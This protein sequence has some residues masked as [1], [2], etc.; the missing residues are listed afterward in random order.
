MT[1]NEIKEFLEHAKANITADL[2]DARSALLYYDHEVDEPIITTVDALRTLVD[3]YMD[4]FSN[5]L[6]TIERALKALEKSE[7]SEEN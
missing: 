5:A 6:P 1:N 7:N 3:S 4:R 2:D